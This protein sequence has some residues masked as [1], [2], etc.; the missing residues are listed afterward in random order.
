MLFRS[1]HLAQRQV[2]TTLDV[3]GPENLTLSEVVEVIAASSGWPPNARHIPLTALRVGAALIRP[4]R[5]DIA[6][7][8]GAAARMDRADMTFDPAEL[9]AR[10][11]HI[12]LTHFT[13]VVASRVEAPAGARLEST[14]ST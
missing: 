2:F 4:F 9:T 12:Q 1:D 8:M 10:Y 11:P 3:G 6:G 5:P 7:L 14:T 13:D